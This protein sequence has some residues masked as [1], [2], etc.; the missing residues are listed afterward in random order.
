[1]SA[2]K[3]LVINPN[4][5]KSITN[6]LQEALDPVCPPGVELSY[7]TAPAHAPPSINDFQ[8]ATLTAVACYQDILEKKLTESY[9]GFLVCCFSDHPLQHL[10]REHLGPLSPRHCIGIFEAGITHA[11]LLN[12]RFGVVSTGTGTKPLLIKGVS[13][14]LGG[15]AS[16]RWAGCVTSGLGVVELR[17]GDPVR[18][19]ERMQATAVEV[20]KKGAG[21]LIMGCAGMAGM[22]GVIKD[23]VRA[24]GLGE[25]RVVDGAK[26]GIEVLAGLVRMQK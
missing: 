21:V 2:I 7:Y 25:V 16:D 5:S 4:S 11:L 19:K 6:G 10:L 18:I 1:M 12:H 24:A 14:F 13:A 3:I 20:V 23:G 8:T 15:S 22:E 17:E 26:A 9:D